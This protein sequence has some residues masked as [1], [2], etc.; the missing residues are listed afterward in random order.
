[1]AAFAND[2][3]GVLEHEQWA[4]QPLA[5][6]ECARLPAYS[7]GERCQRGMQLEAFPNVQG[8]GCFRT[9]C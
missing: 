9:D 4:K 3:N 8:R 7:D 6:Q 2:P 5:A 1:M